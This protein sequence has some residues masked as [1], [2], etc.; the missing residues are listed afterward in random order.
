MSIYKTLVAVTAVGCIT[1]FRNGIQFSK[2]PKQV[3]VTPSE[4]ERLEADSYL[5]V[6]V[7][8][9]GADDDIKQDDTSDNTGDSLQAGD[10]D[11]NPANSQSTTPIAPSNKLDSNQDPAKPAGDEQNAGDENQSPAD[12]GSNEQKTSA[13]NDLTA[14]VE[15]MR[16]LNLDL[17]AVKPTVK[18]LKEQGLEV[19]AKYRD[20]A[21]NVLVA[22]ANA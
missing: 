22:E 2:T 21:W 16:A 4:L 14:I 18:S 7:I 9:Q 13:P 12:K 1:R 10:G 5:Q 11:T 6:K 19:S 17:S 20:A 15:A 3:E 8:S